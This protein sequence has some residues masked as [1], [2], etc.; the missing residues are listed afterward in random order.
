MLKPY[1]KISLEFLL[2]ITSLIFI[3]EGYTQDVTNR[4]QK[5]LSIQ[6]RERRRENSLAE[7]REQLTKASMELEQTKS[8]N[9]YE[10]DLEYI[11]KIDR[12][13]LQEVGVWS[14]NQNFSS[15][16][17]TE[18]QLQKIR[19]FGY[20]PPILRRGLTLE[21]ISNLTVIEE[22]NY[23][24]KEPNSAN[25][26][27]PISDAKWVWDN[28]G[29]D[30]L[31]GTAD[32]EYIVENGTWAYSLIDINEAPEYAYITEMKVDY[33]IN[34]PCRDD[35]LVGIYDENFFAWCELW[36]PLD[37]DFYYDY[38]TNPDLKYC[39]TYEPVIDK[40]I[41]D[42]NSRLVNQKWW[43]CVNDWGPEHTGTL[44]TWKIKIWYNIPSAELADLIITDVR[45]K[46]L[47][48]NPIN[49]FYAPEASNSCPQQVNVEVDIK[50]IGDAPFILNDWW[51][52]VDIILKQNIACN[53]SNL[54]HWGDWRAYEGLENLGVD[55]TITVYFDEAHDHQGEHRIVK[56]VPKY[57][58]MH[59]LYAW[60]YTE[61]N[62]ETNHYNND[63]GPI[64]FQMRQPEDNDTYIWPVEV[65]NQQTRVSGVFGEFRTGGGIHFHEGI[66]IRE[67]DYSTNT[68]VYC[69]SSG[70]LKYSPGW[71]YLVIG[72]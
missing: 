25:K 43:L 31:T 17:V 49:I 68:D 63:Y 15:C 67:P 30:E 54:D 34:H 44:V 23:I 21:K 8:E 14:E 57:Y 4:V 7:L 1:Y 5:Q 19:Y 65:Y 35:L 37:F 71:T 60:L 33:N 46:D 36:T 16:T 51:N 6:E 27:L 9:I 52:S 55:E 47:N 45:I 69:V 53:Y 61:E 10:V 42:Y 41:G 72:D 56:L 59:S 66:D 22:D 24:A 26:N 62:E 58:G 40:Y 38:P 39:T 29:P 70:A 20:D 11:S 28:P 12:N 2:I 48:G 32:D 50:N 13:C 18:E 64:A 3:S